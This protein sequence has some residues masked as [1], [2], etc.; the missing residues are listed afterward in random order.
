LIHKNHLTLSKSLCKE[1]LNIQGK[2]LRIAKLYQTSYEATTSI[3]GG[4]FTMCY[5][6]NIEKAL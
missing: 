6:N 3:S 2:L 1:V 4:E 5:A